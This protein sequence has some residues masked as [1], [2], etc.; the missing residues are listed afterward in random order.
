M[1]NSRDAVD[2]LIDGALA[3][4]SDAEPLAGLEERVANHVRAVRARRRVF[5]WGAAAATACAVAVIGIAM[6]SAQQPMEKPPAALR[7]AHA[8]QPEISKAPHVIFERGGRARPQ[9]TAHRKSLPKLDQF[10]SPSRLTSEEA[11]LAAW[12]RRDPK[13]AEE[14]FEDLRKQADEPLAIQPIQIAPLQ[15]DGAQ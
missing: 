7:M 5:V 12:V 4:Y 8:A 9:R 1:D 6:R 14:I 13:Q 2:R 10:P 3:S 15:I 11:T